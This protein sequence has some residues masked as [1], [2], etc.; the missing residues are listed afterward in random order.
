M[1]RLVS[2]VFL[3]VAASS[4]LSAALAAEVP[5]PGGKHYV[6]ERFETRPGVFF[7]LFQ[8]DAQWEK[9]VFSGLR[10]A[11]PD[12]MTP[13][14][15]LRFDFPDVEGPPGWLEYNV[16][17]ELPRD[18]DK[19]LAIPLDTVGISFF[20]K[21][22]GSENSGR[23]EV[24]EDYRKPGSGADFPLADTKWHRVTLMW[25]D[26]SPQPDLPKILPLCFG[27]ADGA[28]RPAHY[29]IDG[30][31]FLRS[32]E[33]DAALDALAE[34]ANASPAAPRAPELPALSR[35]TYNKEALGKTRA[36]LHE[37]KPIKWLAYG[38]SVTVPVQLWNMPAELHRTYAYYG[39]AAKILEKEFGSQIDVAVN[40]VGGRQLVEDFKSLPA[41]LKSEMPDVLILFSG[42]KVENYER[43]LPKVIEAAESV[44]AEILFVIPTYDG[45]PYRT[46]SLDW[47]RQYCIDN[48]LACADA[49]TLLRGIDEAYWGDTIANVNHPNP[50]GHK[51]IGE[52][53]AEMFK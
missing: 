47:L 25:S 53:V 34:K 33:T 31:R 16:E 28:V 43:L 22:D 18:K 36:A 21:G 27:L 14:V 17:N 2:V 20:V 45:R 12:C 1:I 7:Y 40:A 42:D 41:S 38:D 15:A 29:T 48:K 35:L 26:L 8:T 52:L 32:E 11:T 4:V 44:G 13:P 6:P 10:H 39:V 30:L 50:E 51:L 24:R 19:S 9:E 49:R 37:G 23:V 46:A 3:A 5:V